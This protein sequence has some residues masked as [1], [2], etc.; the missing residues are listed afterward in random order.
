VH[1]HTINLLNISLSYSLEK[2]SKETTLV[3]QV[4]GGYLRSQVRCLQCKTTSNTYDPVLDISVDL[5][6]A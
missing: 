3:H 1:Y 4:F 6:V 5:K 2:L